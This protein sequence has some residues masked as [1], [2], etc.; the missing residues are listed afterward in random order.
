MAGGEI[1]EEMERNID[2]LS[3][4]GDKSVSFTMTQEENVNS[5]LSGASQD[6]R[7]GVSFV[8]RLFVGSAH[9]SHA[10]VMQRTC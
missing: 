7:S 3:V 8:F 10:S 4:C 1:L 9:A 5:N 2:R 6:L